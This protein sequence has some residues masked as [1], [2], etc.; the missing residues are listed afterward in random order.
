MSGPRNVAALIP[1]RPVSEW[2]AA[3]DLNILC[4]PC[5]TRRARAW[6]TGGFEDPVCPHWRVGVSGL[7]I[8]TAQRVIVSKALIAYGNWTVGPPPVL[9]TGP[10]GMYKV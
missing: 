1:L 10:A 8:S 9:D 7:P 3:S 2:F 5:L 4:S 6:A